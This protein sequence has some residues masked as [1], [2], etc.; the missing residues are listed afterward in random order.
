MSASSTSRTVFEAIWEHA[1]L[2]LLC[3]SCARLQPVDLRQL[4]LNGHGRAR[5]SGFPFTCECGSTDVRIMEE[6][7]QIA[8]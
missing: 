6:P 7:A 4:A 1:K 8:A 3:R 5:L 2:A